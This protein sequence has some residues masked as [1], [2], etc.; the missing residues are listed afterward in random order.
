MAELANDDELYFTWWFNELEQA[1]LA[2]DLSHE[3]TQFDIIDNDIFSYEHFDKRGKEK[4]ITKELYERLTWKP[5]FSMLLSRKLE[6]KMFAIIN[7]NSNDNRLILPDN[8]DKSLGNIYQETCLL[9]TTSQIVDDEWIRV[10][11]DVKPP[12]FA[13]QFSSKLSSSRDFRYLKKIM[14]LRHKIYVNKVVTSHNKDVKQLSR[15]NTI[16]YKTFLPQRYLFNNKDGRPRKLKN[17]EKA[18]KSIA[19]Y[20][21]SKKVFEEPQTQNLNQQQELF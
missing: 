16:F 21:E 11:F 17:H 4:I 18:S 3:G 6:G 14:F 5:D 20:L 15:T 19:Q 1:G 8:F 12:A 13:L 9:T 10:W 7:E 2:K